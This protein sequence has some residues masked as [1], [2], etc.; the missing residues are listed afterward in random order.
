VSMAITHPRTPP[1]RFADSWDQAHEAAALEAGSGDF[2]PPDYKWGLRVLLESMDYDPRFTPAGRIGAWQSVTGALA[3]RA[4]AYGAMKANP[5]YAAATIRRP[6]VIYGIPRTGTTALHRLLLEDPQFQGPEKWLLSAPMPRPP[7]ETWEANRWFQKEIGE[8]NARFGDMPDQRAAHN[9]MA[10]EVDECLWLQR[11]SFV[12]HMWATGWSAA[13]YDTW[14]VS[15]TERE[16]YDYLRDCLQMMGMGDSRQWLL[17][18]PS[19]VLHLGE[20]FRIFPDALVIQTHR[21]PAKAV[22]SLCALLMQAHEIMEESRTDLRARTMCLREVAK[23]AKG[24][25]DAMPVR[26]AHAGQVMDVIHGEFHADPMKVVRGIYEFAGLELAPEVE[27]RM[28]G[29]IQAKPEL[30]HGEHRYHVSDFNL[31]E[32]DI[33]EQFADYIEAFDL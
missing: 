5:G 28:A 8:L 9:M 2:G 25:R 24:V 16:S 21:D 10:E 30:A 22:P 4:V 29:R 7:R 15:Q 17:K 26:E 13:T 32:D 31:T 3:S 12:S 23:W 1:A 19:H 20:L 11:H 33:R 18:N 27:E 14:W 6:I